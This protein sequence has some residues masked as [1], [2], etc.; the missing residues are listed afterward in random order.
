MDVVVTFILIL[1]LNTYVIKVACVKYKVHSE[2]YLWVLFGVHV[3]LSV[4]YLMMALSTASD[5]I[6]YYNDSSRESNWFSLWGTSTPFIEFLA[7]PF[8]YLLNLS[9]ISTMMIFSWFGYL[10][11]MYFYIAAK[12]NAPLPA[13]WQKYSVVELVFLLPNLHYW[14]SSLGKGSVI[15][16]GLALLT[17]GLSRFN[18]RYLV[19]AF[20]AFLVFMVRPHILFTVIIS[21][22]LALLIS[23][24]ALKAYVKWIVFAV[25]AVVFFFISD[26]VAKFTEVENFNVLDSEFLANRAAELS[27]SS[28][29]VNLQNYGLLMKMFTFW[30]RPLF[31]DGQ[32]LMGIIVSFENLVYLFMFVALLRFGFTNWKHWNG[33]FK[34]CFFIFLFASVALAQVTGNLGIAIRQKAQIMPFFFI[35]YFKALTYKHSTTLFQRKKSLNWS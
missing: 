1:L 13:V 14:S 3:L 28:S 33:W 10:G 12:E 18:R 32:G 29:G 8:T 20:G 11:V 31:I 22:M 34:I 16:F 19:L 21:V 27:K 4:V 23:G 7:W 24:S 35:L 30:F 17:F 25:A 2:S 9:Y 6:A 5:S 26:D 15:L